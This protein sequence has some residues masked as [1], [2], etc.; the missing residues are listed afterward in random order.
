MTLGAQQGPGRGGG[1][2]AHCEPRGAS[3]L[4]AAKSAAAPA[5]C[6]GNTYRGEVSS[7][8]HRPTCRIN[9]IVNYTNR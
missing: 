1:G 5:G 4:T 2:D 9:S 3:Q 7:H 8:P 6:G